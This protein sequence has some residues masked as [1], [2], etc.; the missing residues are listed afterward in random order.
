MYFALSERT[1]LFF[2]LE[3]EMTTCKL[4]LS[5]LNFV[6]SVLE[7]LASILKSGCS[8]RASRT[9]LYSGLTII[10]SFFFF[11]SQ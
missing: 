4:H 7:F 1:C 6:F 3:L 9:Q 10:F 5:S 11:F 2:F 8:G